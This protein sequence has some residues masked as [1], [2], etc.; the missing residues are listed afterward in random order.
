MINGIKN[1]DPVPYGYEP[2]DT[3]KIYYLGSSRYWK[4]EEIETFSGE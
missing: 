2:L 1:K 3:E 4:N